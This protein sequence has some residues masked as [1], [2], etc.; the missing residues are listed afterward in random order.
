MNRQS[1]ASAKPKELLTN[2]QCQR[3]AAHLLLPQ[4]HKITFDILN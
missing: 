1:N 2:A 4:P 3:F